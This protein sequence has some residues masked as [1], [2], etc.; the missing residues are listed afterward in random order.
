MLA[1]IDCSHCAS[2]QRSVHRVCDLRRVK[3]GRHLKTEEI[4]YLNT[5]NSFKYCQMHI[6]GGKRK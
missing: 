5:G 3:V 4:Y 1:H 6:R 2:F